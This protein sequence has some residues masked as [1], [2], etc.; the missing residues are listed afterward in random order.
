MPK[1]E[2]K[3]KDIAR[4]V[5]VDATATKQF[6]QSR[7]PWQGR[8][9]ST[10]RPAINSKEDS[11]LDSIDTIRMMQKHQAAIEKLSSREWTVEQFFNGVGPDIAL[12]LLKAA[13][14]ADSSKVR[15]DAI[16]DF[17]DRAGYTKVQKVAVANLDPNAPKEQLR[18]IA[19][20]LIKK[21]A[22]DVELVDDDDE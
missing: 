9:N 16:K 5:V 15:L 2:I 7:D 14:L 6:K 17:L 11:M 10:A 22:N 8:G 3:L 12:E 1:D 18:A 13:Y 19:E 4:Q 21:N 20:G